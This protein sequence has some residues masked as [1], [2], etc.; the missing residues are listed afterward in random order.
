MYLAGAAVAAVALAAAQPAKALPI[1]TGSLTL[2]AVLGGEF[3]VDTTDITATTSSVTEPSL[4]V[5]GISSTG[6]LASAISLGDGASLSNP[7]LPVPSAVGTFVAIAPFTITVDG[8]VFTFDTVKMS[9]PIVAT[10]V[11]T[12]GSFDEQFDGTLT[13]GN[14]EFENGTAVRFSQAC[15]Q[16]APT[17]LIGCG[18][19]SV[20]VNFLSPPGPI[21]G[22]PEP[23]SLTIL[24][25][26]LLGFGL[27][28]RRR[29]R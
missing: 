3:T 4:I 24:G 21:T 18:N 1:A 9:N 27:L 19:S 11:L 16:A 14:G 12:S 22:V 8:L 23:A 25:A 29:T 26:S 7:T 17:A 10:T 13:N 6:N 2:Q 15:T 5:Q 28:R 20:I